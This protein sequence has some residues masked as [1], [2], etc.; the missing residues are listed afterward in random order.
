GTFDD[1]FVIK[2]INNDLGVND[3]D[4]TSKDLI[5]AVKNKTIS[6]N[7]QAERIEK[8]LVYDISG[9]LIYNKNK[10]GNSSFDFSIAKTNNQVLL[11]KTQLENGHST[12]RK[13]FL[14]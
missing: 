3:F 4:K 9:K 7:A 13:V 14:H 10:I 1:R 6:V 2:F 5:V 8:I 11:V 12:D